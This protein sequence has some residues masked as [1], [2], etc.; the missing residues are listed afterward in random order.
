MSQIGIIIP[1]VDEPCF[2]EHAGK[3]SILVD[4]SVLHRSLIRIPDDL[5]VLFEP[6]EKQMDL[7]HRAPAIHIGIE[8][9]QVRVVRDRFVVGLVCE[10]LGK[11]LREGGFAR[12]DDS[13]NPYEHDY[14]KL[15][16]QSSRSSFGKFIQVPQKVWWTFSDGF[17]GTW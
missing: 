16:A 7:H 1:L 17:G 14:M 10:S 9:L 5:L 15:L 8:I 6:A 4:G 3:N 11:I 2:V 13:R 12:P